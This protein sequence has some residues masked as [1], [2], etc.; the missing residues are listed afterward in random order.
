MPFPPGFPEPPRYTAQEFQRLTPDERIKEIGRIFELGMAMIRSSPD[1]EAIEKRIDEEKE[2][3][4]QIQR[5]IFARYL[6]QKRER[7]EGAESF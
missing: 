4:K 6:E 3:W 7:G 5:E 2:Q 1:R